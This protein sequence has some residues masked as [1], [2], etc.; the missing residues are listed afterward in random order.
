[1]THYHFIGIGGTGLAP[2]AR[3]LLEKGHTVSGSDKS[4]STQTREFQNLGVSVTIGHTPANIE[5]ADFVIRSS[6]VKD[7]NSEIQAA[8]RNKIPVLKRSEFLPYLIGNQRCIAV[9]GT[10]GKTTTTA[11]IAWMLFACGEDPSYVIGGVSKN[12]NSNA[13]FGKGSFFVIEADEYDYM[14]YGLSP[15]LAIV[16]HVE[17][18]HP[19]MFPTP[20]MY[21]EAFRGFVSRIVLDGTVF[22]FADD[23]G[24]MALLASCP[25]GRKECSYGFD[26]EA[27][28]RAVEVTE[29]HQGG[30][31][32]RVVKTDGPDLKD[33]CTIN[34]QVPGKHNVSN[35]TAAV[36][37]A[38][39]LRLPFERMKKALEEFNGVSRRFDIVG[40]VN[41]ITVVDDYA[42][43]PT[44]IQATLSAARSKYPSGRLWV[45]W[46]PH[47]Y[48]R[49]LALKN[50][51][52]H[53]FELADQLLVTEVYAAREKNDDFSSKSFVDQISTPSAHFVKTFSE[54]KKILLDGLKPQDVLLV[55]SAGDA[56]QISADVVTSL[57][58]R[59]GKNGK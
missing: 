44:E 57:K 15:W 28:Y 30:Y 25:P 29:N 42:H 1:M 5:G 56:D 7:D 11:M 24:A 37:I 19:D 13:H 20:A 34:L 22:T 31:T 38:D 50:G 23:P 43:H 9:A 46:Q 21:E 16:T 3:V 53:A 17:Y 52:I 8:L 47:T 14:F 2:I 18:D 40:E 45:V 26:I 41:G 10:H 6:A 51:F 33:L 49:T 12:L 32:F 36:A 35:A 58:E 48:S 55:L 39:T 54:A 27:D 4:A 59:N